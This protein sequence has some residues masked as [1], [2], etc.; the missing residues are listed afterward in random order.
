MK[1]ILFIP[2]M[3]LLFA[4][5]A[6]LATA[7]E[8]A[9]TS[10]EAIEESIEVA[11]EE[12]GEEEPSLLP[13]S[14]FYFFK[15]WWRSIDKLFTFNPVKKID[16]ELAHADQRLLEARKLAEKTGKEEI[17]EKAMDRYERA[18]ERINERIR[19]AEEKFEDNPG[20]QNILDKWTERQIFHQRIMERMEEM[21]ENAPERIEE[22]LERLRE[23]MLE[24]FGETASQIDEKEE[25]LA[26]R[27]DRAMQRAQGTSLRMLKNLEI[28]EELEEK[29]PESA[30]PAIKR[31]QE[32]AL[33]R[34]DA[35]L[36]EENLEEAKEKI[37]HYLEAREGD[38]QIRPLEILNKLRERENTRICAQVLTPA[39]NQFTKKCWT[40][41]TSCLPEGW[42]V[43]RT[44]KEAIS[45]D[46][47]VQLREKMQERMDT[48]M[49]SLNQ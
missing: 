24:R 4:L 40:F 38:E 6:G 35:G 30:L 39:R 13:D 41:K 12:L 10:E 23:R 46:D 42:Q 1:K 47:A 34:L 33:K 32:N 25:V 8:E 21:M 45:P 28:L 26:E 22:N 37:E 29:I 48:M 49:N 16:K 17:L 15:E 2:M 5:G 14:P 19:K 36:R 43:D 9:T 31:A 20:Y 44:C 3:F 7:Q 27:L 18:T 11:A